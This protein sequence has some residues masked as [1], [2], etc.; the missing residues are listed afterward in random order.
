[1]KR[2]RII[3]YGLSFFLCFVFIFSLQAE[4]GMLPLSEIPRLDLKSLGFKIDANELY[5]P[6]GVSLIDGIINLRGCTA[7]FVSPDGLILTNYHCAFRAV[8]TVTTKEN[9]YMRDGFIARDRSQ[10]LPAKG[11]TVRVIEFYR[12]VSKD[13]LGVVKKEMTYAQRTRAIEKQIKKIEVNTEK[14]YPGRRAEV[15]E[16]FI[17]K[18][19]VLFVYTYLK[20]VRL[21]YAP[22][23]SIGEYGGEIDNW[24]WPRHTGDFAFMR[25]Y[26]AP[27][28]SFTDYSPNNV[29]YHPKKYL[30]AAPE[31]VKEEDLVFILG[32]PGRTARHRTSYFISF[33]E[34]VRMPCLVELYGWMINVLEKLSEKD[35]TVEIKLS[36]KLNGLWNSMKRSQGQLQ[37]LKNLELAKKRKEKENALQAFIQADPQRQAKYGRVLERIAE[38]FNEK[39]KDA[40]YDFILGYLLRSSTMLGNAYKVVEA[41]IERKKKDTERESAYMN[42]NFDRTL[43][44]IEINLGNYCEEADKILFKE[45]LMR[46]A[47]P[48]GDKPQRIPAVDNIILKDSV[49][50]NHAAKEKAIDAFINSAYTPSRLNDKDFLMGLFEKPNK[51]IKMIKDPFIQLAVALYPTYQEQKEKQKRQ[52]GILDELMS[53]LINV[54]KEFMGIEFIP[55]ANGTLRLTYGRIRGYSPAD[56]VYYRPF[57]TL[58]GVIQKNT[59]KHPFNAPKKLIHLYE[60]TKPGLFA[61]PELKDVPVAMLYNTDTTGGSSGS[62][63]LNANGRLVGLNFDRV[64]EGTI[65]DYAWD[66]AYSRSIGVDIRYILWFLDK[67]GGARHLLKEM[68]VQ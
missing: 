38:L 61:H 68:N 2:I 32:Y 36:P 6:N 52:K 9:D 44:R 45:L 33:E 48:K 27:D 8:Q 53:Q 10:E 20:D 12:D 54:K 19:Y 13:V 62:P 11:Y 49:K 51:E 66:E 24:M 46:A 28:G 37:G 4:E 3:R 40:E 18:T 23:R 57:T 26:S 35:R 5:N 30:Q 60:T 16:M 55:D 67:F 21:V 56:A 22:P 47:K 41:S 59:G 39:R 34:Q 17:G 31:G 63:V 7:S 15:A 1:M 14:M 65:N 29:P 43:K 64:F 25:A 58:A 42:R 50:G